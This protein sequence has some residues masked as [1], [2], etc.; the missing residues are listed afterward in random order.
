MPTQNFLYKNAVDITEHIS[1]VI[2][3]VGYVVDNEDDYFSMVTMLTAMP[4]DMMVQLD[5]IGIDFSTINEYELFLLLFQGL[6]DRDTSMIF[7]DLDLSKFR[8]AVDENDNLFIVDEESGARID[9]VVYGQIAS[10]LRK[11]HFLEKNIKK[12]GNEEARKF[13]IE[14]ARK[15][16]NRE[17]RKKK[18]S[19]FEHLIVS[20]VNT[21]QY[22]YDYETTRNLTIYQF[23]SSVHQIVRKINYDNLMIGCYAGTIKT[24]EINQDALDWLT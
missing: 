20:M 14:R 2:P 11:I 18:D 19:Y 21:E 23:N 3:D 10:T 16:Q 15:K 13:M 17:A 4:I 5:D 7:G 1:I 9:R 8:A 12:P 24:T 22:K 6:V